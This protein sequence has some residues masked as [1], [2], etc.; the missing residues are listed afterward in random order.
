MV[1]FCLFSIVLCCVYC[2]VFCCVVLREIVGLE[3]EEKSEKSTGNEGVGKGGEKWCDER[4]WEHRKDQSVTMKEKKKSNRWPRM[5]ER[6]WEWEQRNHR[7]GIQ[8]EKAVIFFLAGAV[9]L[10]NLPCCKEILQNILQKSFLLERERERERT[11]F[12]CISTLKLSLEEFSFCVFNCGHQ[13][14][15]WLLS[16]LCLLADKTL[17]WF[18]WPPERP[19]QQTTPTFR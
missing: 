11:V 10:F 9:F 16:R 19:R 13:R 14:L 4:K 7:R 6:K 5:S 3:L 2:S 17:L 15:H 1:S 12:D 18:D 8:K